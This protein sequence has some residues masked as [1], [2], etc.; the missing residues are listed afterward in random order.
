[1]QLSPH[2]AIFFTTSL[3]NYIFTIFYPILLCH[4]GHFSGHGLKR[5]TVTHPP[6][7]LVLNEIIS[8]IASV[9]ITGEGYECLSKS[10]F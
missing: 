5:V 8:S 9:F 2:T 3:M 1:M 7:F 4:N 10:L 6:F